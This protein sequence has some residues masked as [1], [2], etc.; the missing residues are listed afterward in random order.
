MGKP[1]SERFIQQAVAE[2]LNKDY[3]RRR[4]AY[5]STEA[6]TQLK[7]ADV[8]LAFMRAPKRP[9]VVVVEAK[10]RNTIRQLRLNKHTGEWAGRLF[11]LLPLIGLSA[12]LGY[13]GYSY[14]WGGMLWGF[15]L[16]AA[17]LLAI[18]VLNILHQKLLRSIPAIRQLGRYP[19]NES[20]VAVGEDTFVQA[21]NLSVLRKHCRKNGVGL[22]LVNDRGNLSFRGDT[23]T[24]TYL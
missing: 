6:Y 16:V 11:Y 23:Q 7:R 24:P 14:Q 15:V 8:L 17:N 4:T 13:W 21:G 12:Y 5:V 22:I 18:M 1:L 3:Y 9:Y 19:A 20:W 10:S 2:R